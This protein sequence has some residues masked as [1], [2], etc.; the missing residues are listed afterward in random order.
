MGGS[1]AAT[2][3]YVYRGVSLTGGNPALQADVHYQP[4]AAW[5][6]GV[7]ASTVD[8]GPDHDTSLELDLY[9]SRNWVIHQ[10]WDARLSLTHYA[11]LNDKRP[12]DYDYDEV[13]GSLIYQSRL[14]ATIAWSPDVSR[15]SNGRVA[16]RKTATSYELTATQPL[17]NMLSATAGAGYYDLSALFNT[18][19]WFWNAGLTWSVGGAEV[20]VSYMATDDT[21]T[22]AFGYDNA[23]SRWTG[24]LIWRF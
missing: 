13:T 2:T 12:L 8:T 22:H 4:D 6:F 1:L 3:D 15:F 14:A 20:A 16:R 17:F 18:G 21:A 11:Y 9:A 7:W 19:Y 5:T 10:D 24:M 23:G